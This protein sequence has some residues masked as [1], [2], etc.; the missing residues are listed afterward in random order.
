MKHWFKDQQLR[1]LLRNTSYLGM[2]RAVA[3][4]CGIATIAF[5]GRGLGLLLLGTLILITSYTKAVSGLAKFQSWQVIVRYGGHGVAHGDPEHFRIATGFAFSLDLVSGIAGMLVA[6]ALLPFISQWVGIQPQYLWLGMFYCTLLPTTGAA[7]PTGVLRV[8]DRFDLIGWS[9]TLTPISRAILAGLAFL[10][11]APFAAYV[12]IW[13]VTDLAGDLLTWFLAFRELRRTG[14]LESIR[15]TLRPTELA[16]AWRFAIDVNLAASVQAIWGP[17]GRLVVGG[18]LGPAGAALFRVASTLADSAQKPAD[19]LG[20]AFYPEIIRMD[21]TTNKPWKLMLRVM[22]LASGIAVF[23]IGL[24]LV[25]GKPLMS[26]VFGKAFLAAYEP[27]VIL[28][29]IPVLGIFGFPLQPM[30]YALGR[31]DAP[32]KAKLIATAVFFGT[33]A[34]LCWAFGVI[35]AAVALVLGNAAN[36]TAMML[37]LKGERGRVSKR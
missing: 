30:L 13:Y 4:I 33:I 2:S 6:V 12:V 24:L 15:P 19:L 29:L 7:T 25:G 22:V 34:P 10:A 28:M 27:L 23:A 20:R 37:Q 16:G 5:A 14:H 21:F 36:I 8:L 11:N 9:D 31:S 26:V 1:S 3:A 17:T 35:G 18:L 32:L